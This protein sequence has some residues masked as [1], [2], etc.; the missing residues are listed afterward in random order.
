VKTRALLPLVPYI[1]GGDSTAAKIL[2]APSCRRPSNSIGSGT[3][4]DFIG[5]GGT[6]DNIL[7]KHFLVDHSSLD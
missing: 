3:V 5:T 7:T 4:M 1:A 6:T 2:H